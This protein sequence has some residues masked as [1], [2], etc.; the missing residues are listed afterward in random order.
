[1]ETITFRII[2]IDNHMCRIEAK[3]IR[4]TY[5]TIA[6][7]GCICSLDVMLAEMERITK[8]VE[9]FGNNAI[10]TLD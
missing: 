7:R 3:D 5:R 9:Q 6:L 10:F 1:M 4:G 8:E 2:K